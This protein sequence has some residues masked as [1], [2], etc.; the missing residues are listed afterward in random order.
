MSLTAMYDKSFYSKLGIGKNMHQSLRFWL[1]VANII[2]FNDSNKTHVFTTFGD[3]VKDND[4]G[5]DKKTTLLLIQYY[6]TIG[7]KN[8]K[9]E[10]AEG[11]HW[12]FYVYKEKSMTREK[13]KQ[14][15]HRYNNQTSSKTLDREID[16]LLQTYTKKNKSHP[17]DK[18]I[19]LLAK[20]GLVLKQG[21]I[22]M[23][24]SLKKE[25]YSNNVF[26]Y[27]LSYM[28]EQ[29]IPLTIDNIH[30]SECGI[31]KAYNLTRS[32][33]VSVIEDLSKHSFGVEITRTNNLDSVIISESR[34]SKELL[35]DIYGVWKQ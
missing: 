7:E 33:L 18:N 32:Q 19:S 8:L 11:F 26:M 14:D 24:T 13:L 28:K 6:L 30:N 3:Q 1:E 4:P 9:N 34:S 35:E 29:N 31:S 5:C 23:K 12:F 2:R 20:L 10:I 27:I 17:E 21:N 15:I 16:C 25:Y 22:Y